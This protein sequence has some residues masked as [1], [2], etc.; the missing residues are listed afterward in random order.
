MLDELLPVLI[1]VVLDLKAP[2]PLTI[3][4]GAARAFCLLTRKTLDITRLHVDVSF[5]R[6]YAFWKRALKRS[7]IPDSDPG[8]KANRTFFDF[9]VACGPFSKASDADTLLSRWG[10]RPGSPDDLQ[11]NGLCTPSSAI[12]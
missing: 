8:E 9:L 10:D 11:K 1:D 2:I 7:G 4:S 6:V 3:R 5:D 12:S